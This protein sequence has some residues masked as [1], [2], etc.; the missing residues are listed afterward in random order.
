MRPATVDAQ[1]AVRV[2]LMTRYC[3]G[4]ERA[5]RELHHMTAPRLL[6]YLRSLTGD[7]ASA[8]DALQV[9]FGKFH[10]ARASYT[11]GADPLPWLFAIAHRTFLDEARRRR[12]ARVRLTRDAE[13]P[14]VADV[15]AATRDEEEGPYAAELVA[16][17]I[18]ALHRLPPRQREA[19][20]LTKLQGKSQAEAAMILGTT[21]GALKLRA[22]RAY[23]ALRQQL[24]AHLVP[25]TT[26]RSAA[27]A[28]R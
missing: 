25:E 27:G 14:D 4:C 23:A 17:V 20:V 21:E 1:A 5:F 15:A 19:V 18:E 16:A 8:E 10:R 13:L 28:S 22:H 24:P 9:T 26:R 7:R 12:R 11:P 6:P 2:E 3:R